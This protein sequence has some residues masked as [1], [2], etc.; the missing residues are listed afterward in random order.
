[1]SAKLAC[2]L[3]LDFDIV[4]ACS[5]ATGT[6]WRTISD[7]KTV[8][9]DRRT[10]PENRVKEEASVLIISIS[11][12]T[13]IELSRASGNKNLSNEGNFFSPAIGCCRIVVAGL[14]NRSRLAQSEPASAQ[15]LPPRTT[16]VAAG[17]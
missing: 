12:K 1:M 7:P 15:T 14:V 13:R 4:E 3:R 11:T 6:F 5:A 16:E 2:G 10:Q 8:E 9:A 17:A